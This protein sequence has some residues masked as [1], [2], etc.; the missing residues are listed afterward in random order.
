[1]KRISARRLLELESDSLA[2]HQLRGVRAARPFSRESRRGIVGRTSRKPD[3]KRRNPT[4]CSSSKSDSEAFV[5]AKFIAVGSESSEPRLRHD[6]RSAIVCSS[7]SNSYAAHR[8]AWA[9][10][11]GD[12][13]R[14]RRLDCGGFSMPFS[15]SSYV[16]VGF[17][18]CS[19]P[20]SGLD[21]LSAFYGQRTI[22]ADAELKVLCRTA[23]Q[24]CD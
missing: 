9:I 23:T 1:M 6:H 3:E 17:C 22:P 11:L 2:W 8:F 13:L 18:M 14:A 20:V 7:G 16:P 19:S 4:R 15:G 21:I 10:R 5:Q 24:N 12:S